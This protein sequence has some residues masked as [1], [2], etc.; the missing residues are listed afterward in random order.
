MSQRRL[1]AKVVSLAN[2]ALPFSPMQRAS[3]HVEL[4]HSQYQGLVDAIA[5]LEETLSKGDGDGSGQVGSGQKPF[6]VRAPTTSAADELAQLEADIKRE[7]LEILALKELKAEREKEV[8]A[9]RQSLGSVYLGMRT[10]SCWTCVYDAD[11]TMAAF[12]C[13]Q[14]SHA[15][16]IHSCERRGCRRHQSIN[17]TSRAF[18]SRCPSLGTRHWRPTEQG[19]THQRLPFPLRHPFRLGEYRP[20]WRRRW[21]EKQ[22]RRL[23]QQLHLQQWRQ[24]IPTQRPGKMYEK[25][26]REGSNQRD[27][28]LLQ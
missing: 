15:T 8:S 12:L 14:H 7:E 23:P 19:N 22:S 26:R 16:S 11:A 4:L 6:N 1:H 13:S 2:L 9:D 28:A 21:P 17:A 25:K 18:S 10:G 27:L 3:E 24:D 5:D 20:S